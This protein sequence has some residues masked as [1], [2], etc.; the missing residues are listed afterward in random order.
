MTLAGGGKDRAVARRDA[1][2]WRSGGGR[3]TGAAAGGE[4]P[5]PPFLPCLRSGGVEMGEINKKKIGV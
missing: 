4:V 1:C 3:A 2:R 5:P